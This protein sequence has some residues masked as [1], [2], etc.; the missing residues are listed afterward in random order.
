MLRCS[1]S[2]GKVSH[3]HDASCRV[4]WFEVVWFAG[5]SRFSLAAPRQRHVYK[6][7]VE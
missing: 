3:R 1:V 7:K 5:R 2:S 6:L 4:N